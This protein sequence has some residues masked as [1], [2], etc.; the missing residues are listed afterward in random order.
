MSSL[1]FLGYLPDSQLIQGNP[2]SVNAALQQM[3]VRNQQNP[4]STRKK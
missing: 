3:Q 4:V 2:G 1:I